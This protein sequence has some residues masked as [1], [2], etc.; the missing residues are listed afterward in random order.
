MALVLVSVPCATA[1]PQQAGSSVQTNT[2]NITGQAVD[3]NNAGLSN[4]KV[5]LRAGDAVTK[6]TTTGSSGQ[7]SFS[8]VPNGT[9]TLEITDAAGRVIATSSVTVAAGQTVSVTLTSALISQ[10]GAAA[11][12]GGGTFLASTGFLVVAGAAAA[13]TVTVVATKDNASSNK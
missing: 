2:G 9:Y 8:E 1:A 7:F 5:Q 4:Y 11:A 10:I 12:A 13:A 6:S 3:G